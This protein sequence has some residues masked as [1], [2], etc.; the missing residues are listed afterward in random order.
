VT[1]EGRIGVLVAALLFFSVVGGA[2]GARGQAIDSRTRQA[3]APN[4]SAKERSAIAA[5][6]AARRRMYEPDA[7]ENALGDEALK[8]RMLV[9]RVAIAPQ[10]TAAVDELRTHE[11]KLRSLRE[12]FH[13][14]KAALASEAGAQIERV[15]RAV[16]ELAGKLAAVN[17]AVSAAER[18]R[19][20]RELLSEID[21]RDPL[22]QW[23]RTHP[24]RPT[25]LFNLSPAATDPNPAPTPVPQPRTT[26]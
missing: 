5:I 17:G 26:K 11:Q 19:R 6:L 13:P 16:D 4:G 9:A 3:N 20:A 10:S 21:A 14:A 24:R 12:S 23:K 7:S 8:T 25:I 22:V 2:T 15:H 18:G 1:H